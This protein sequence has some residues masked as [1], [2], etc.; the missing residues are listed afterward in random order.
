MV[1]LNSRDPS[2]PRGLI[3]ALKSTG[4]SKGEEMNQ[5]VCVILTALR[6]DSPTKA[7]EVARASVKAMGG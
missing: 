6:P 3:L 7:S 2:H 1:N 5:E 4:E